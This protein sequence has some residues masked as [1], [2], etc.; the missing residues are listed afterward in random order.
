MF[1]CLVENMRAAK[2][3]PSIE[4]IGEDAEGGFVEEIGFRAGQ[5]RAARGAF[6]SA[7]E[8]F[9]F[10]AASVATSFQ[11]RLGHLHPVGASQP[12]VCPV[13]DGLDDALHAPFFAA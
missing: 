13:A 9:D 6:Q 8:A 2:G 10:P 11:V 3:S 1:K 4:S 5:Q 12:A 7:D